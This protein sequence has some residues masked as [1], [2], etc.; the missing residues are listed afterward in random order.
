MVRQAVDQ[1]GS[2]GPEAF[3][4]ARQENLETIHR[5]NVVAERHGLMGELQQ[6]LATGDHLPHHTT[7]REWLGDRA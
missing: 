7:V 2:L 1:F 3:V 6:E 5:H 4:M